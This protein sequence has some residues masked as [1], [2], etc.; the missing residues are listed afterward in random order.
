MSRR[1]RRHRAQ[2]RDKQA[3]QWK[4]R[5]IRWDPHVGRRIG[6]ASNPGSGPGLEEEPPE[7]VFS[8]PP[9]CFLDV[10]EDRGQALPGLH[11]ASDSDSDSCRGPQDDDDSDSDHEHHDSSTAS[12]RHSAPNDPTP[13]DD[14][15]GTFIP[16]W[17]AH[18]NET[19]SSR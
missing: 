15:N 16:I 9:D 19:Q 17:D 1:L 11:D 10:D 3:K 5:C 12:R 13:H 2:L 8:N 6:E 14:N 7:H 4:Q 18:L